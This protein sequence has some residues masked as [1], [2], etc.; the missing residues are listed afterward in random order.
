LIHQ[1][2]N[3]RK[4][5][6]GKFDWIFIDEY[7][8]TLLDVVKSLVKARSQC[9]LCLGLFGNS[10]KEISSEWIGYVQSYIFNNDSNLVQKNDNYRCSPQVIRISNS[11]RCDGLEQ[12]IALKVKDGVNEIM[13]SREGSAMLY[14]AMAPE[15]VPL[16]G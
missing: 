5:L 1:H 12:E 11:F 7:Q 3:L 9:K 8:D 15:K 6:S 2:Q 4:I 14:F 10:K 13:E 16:K